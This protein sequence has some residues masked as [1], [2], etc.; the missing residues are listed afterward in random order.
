MEKFL[1]NLGLCAR[2][3]KLVSGEDQVLQSISKKSVLV[4]VSDDIQHNTYDKLKRKCQAH[5]IK[6]WKCK[7]NKYE[8]GS[9]IGKQMRVALSIED[10]G[11]AKMIMKDE[12]SSYDDN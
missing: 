8:I 2:A 10:D 12:V 6:F 7:Y 9:A 11:F 5:N 1:N 4:I 3:R